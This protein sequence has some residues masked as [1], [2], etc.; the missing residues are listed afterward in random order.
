VGFFGTNVYAKWAANGFRLPTEAEWEKAARGGFSGQRFP[1][2]N[3]I[4]FGQANYHSSKGIQLE[5]RTYD[6]APS[7]TDNPAFADGFAPN[8]SPVGYFI[9]NGYGVFDM[10]GNVV[11]WCWD[12]YYG[13]APYPAGSAYLGGSDPRGITAGT[14]RIGRG[15]SWNNY[16]QQSTCAFRAAFGPG[17]S[18]TVMG[19][20]C[21]RRP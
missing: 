10:S 1:W 19:F 5:N 15:G 8:T 13:A 18:S 11:E 4:S 21:V 9:P 2:G 12:W 17:F 14:Q 20:R 16:P 6:L 3:T 7:A